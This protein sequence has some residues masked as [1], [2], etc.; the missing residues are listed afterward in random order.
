M[1]G[2]I[3]FRVF[4]VILF[5]ALLQVATVLKKDDPIIKT[6]TEP[7]A[8]KEK[9]EE[10]KDGVKGAPSPSYKHYPQDGFV[11]Q[12]TVENEK[13]PSQQS[14]LKEAEEVWENEELDFIALDDGE[15]EDLEFWEEE[16]EEEEE[17]VK[18]S[19]QLDETKRVSYRE[20]SIDKKAGKSIG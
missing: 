14:S 15:E 2:G 10:T 18:E 19:S 6:Q 9:V 17:E 1:D 20:G 12:E 3:K 5:C 16:E 4:F 7:I 13:E 8:Y 11:T